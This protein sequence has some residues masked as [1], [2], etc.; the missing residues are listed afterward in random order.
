MAKHNAMTESFEEV[1]VLKK[2]ALFTPARINR[3]TIPKGY[4]LY[5][6]RHDDDCQGDAVQIALNIMV[7]HWGSIILREEIPLPKDGYLDI[8]PGDVN[9]GVDVN[10]SMSD[11][12]TKYPLQEGVTK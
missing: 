4:Y 3:A 10:V 7:N 8:E 6:I 12:M 9:Y 2:P 5:E 1:E 11:F